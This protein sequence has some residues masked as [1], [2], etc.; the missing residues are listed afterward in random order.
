MPQ[1]PVSRIWWSMPRRSSTARSW[2]H[3]LFG[4]AVVAVTLHDGSG[5]ELGWLPVEVLGEILDER[6]RLFGESLGVFV[7]GQ[8][9][10]ELVAEHVDAAGFEADDVDPGADLRTQ[11]LEDLLE[12]AAG[13]FEHAEVVQR[14]SAAERASG[15]LDGASRGF[16]H[17]HGRFGD[18]RLEVVCERVGPQDHPPPRAGCDVTAG[19]P[20]CERLVGEAG[21]CALRRDSRDAFPDRCARERVRR[22]GASWRRRGPI[23]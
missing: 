23:A 1:Q 18:I 2:R 17:L 4:G 3:T 16:E 15:E 10:C 5:I 8:H 19:K 20:A 13:E 7:V 21:Q 11:P 6:E 12:V 9:V 14:T 22:G